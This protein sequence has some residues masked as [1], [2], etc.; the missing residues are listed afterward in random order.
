MALQIAS[1][2]HGPSIDDI[3]ARLVGLQQG[4]SDEEARAMMAAL[5]LVLINQIPDTAAVMAAIDVVEQAFTESPS[6]SGRT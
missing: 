3:Y 1:N 5:A 2:P 6:E 4:R